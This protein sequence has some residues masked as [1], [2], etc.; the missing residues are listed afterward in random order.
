MF[1]QRYLGPL[2]RTDVDPFVIIE[3]GFAGGSSAALFRELLPRGTLH[4]FEVGCSVP[5]DGPVNGF[6]YGSPLFD[7]MRREGRLHCGSGADAAFVLPVLREKIRE[8]PLVVIDDGG[9]SADEMIGS[10]KLFFPYIKPCGLFFM[11]DIQESYRLGHGFHD[12]VIDLMSARRL[13]VCSL[14]A[15]CCLTTRKRGPL[16][17]CSDHASDGR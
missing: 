6:I 12:E 16:V 15:Y 2:S 11:E 1:A 7:V 8:P 14:C 4:E 10:F 13:F 5:Y 17:I 9:H 3:I